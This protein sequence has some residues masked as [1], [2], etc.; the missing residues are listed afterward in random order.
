VE[1]N[2][3]HRKE[4]VMK[5]VIAAI[6]AVAEGLK[7]SEGLTVKAIQ[8]GVIAAVNNAGGVECKNKNVTAMLRPAVAHPDEKVRAAY[9]SQEDN[10]EGNPVYLKVVAFYSHGFELADGN[11]NLLRNS[12][13][14]GYMLCGVIKGEI[15][16]SKDGI[17]AAE[18][19]RVM[20]T[21][22]ISSHSLPKFTSAVNA[23]IQRM[24]TNEDTKKID[25]TIQELHE[26]LH[27]TEETQE[28]ETDGAETEEA[29]QEEEEEVLPENF[30]SDLEKAARPVFKQHGI[31]YT[32]QAMADFLDTQGIELAAMPT[33]FKGM[34][35]Y[36]QRV[37][38]RKAEAAAQ[39]AAEKAKTA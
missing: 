39:A 33:L 37:N 6:S 32:I 27:G 22:G 14:F 1:K 5:K 16:I 8:A 9:Q 13:K 31:K 2:S 35:D 15:K 4:T 24:T 29:P 7:I 25:W 12:F 3:I 18:I 30:L 11:K 23:V 38:M 17:T 28:E 20:T 19:K 21:L 26:A 34:A 10:Q 36:G